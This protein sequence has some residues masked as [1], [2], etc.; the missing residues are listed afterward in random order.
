MRLKTNLGSIPYEDSQRLVG[1]RLTDEEGGK[2]DCGD[3]E[4]TEFG[5]NTKPP[6]SDSTVEGA[7]RHIERDV[8]LDI[9][10]ECFHEINVTVEVAEQEYKHG[11]ADYTN[12]MFSSQ[13]E[14]EEWAAENVELIGE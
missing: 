6:T 8:L 10:V 12:W 11:D 13:H 5:G 4:W 3:M 9:K 7:L 14:F 1:F 2:I